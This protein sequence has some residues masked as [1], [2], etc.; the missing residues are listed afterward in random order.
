MTRVLCRSA[1]AL[2]DLEIAR[3]ANDRA[4]ITLGALASL[5]LACSGSARDVTPTTTSEASTPADATAGAPGKPP[6]A[7]GPAGKSPAR[8]APHDGRPC[9]QLTRGACLTSRRCTLVP[10]AAKR[11]G[12]T[13][14]AEQAPCEVGIAQRGLSQNDMAEVALCAGRAGCQL[15]RGSC[16]CPCG[17]P[18]EDEKNCS[19]VCGGGAPPNCV[20]GTVE[21]SGGSRGPLSGGAGAGARQAF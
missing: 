18:S 13:C 3:G 8:E 1:V 20:A 7:G 2:R 19:C 6:G 4:S 21:K 11:G 16:Y 5:V 10:N 17:G 9:E 12:Y 14:R 15:D